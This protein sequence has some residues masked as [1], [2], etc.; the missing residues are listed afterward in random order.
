MAMKNRNWFQV[1]YD[2]PGFLKQFSPDCIHGCFAIFASPTGKDMI[3][4]WCLHYQHIVASDHD[5]SPGK[6]E[7]IGW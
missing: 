7:T 3:S 6:Y 1:I 5:R 4:T 2:P